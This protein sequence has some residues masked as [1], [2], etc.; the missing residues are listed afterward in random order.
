MKLHILSNYNDIYTPP[1]AIDYIVPY[2]PKDKTYREMCYGKWHMANELKKRWYNVIWQE[3][4]D[5]FVEN[6]ECDII[7][8]NPPFTWNKKFV[9]RAIDLWKPFVFLLRL[10]H[11][12]WVQA[13]KMFKDMNIEI[14]IPK[15]RI[16]FITPKVLRW[17][18]VWWSTYHCIYLTY[19]LWI[20]K[21]I[22]YQE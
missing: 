9:Q 7:I 16:N 17:E 1:D 20:W 3:D 10:E 11:L 6:P 15:N 2:L 4:W 18:K 22:T 19:G 12:W 14:I 8:T 13:Y 21:T 5:C